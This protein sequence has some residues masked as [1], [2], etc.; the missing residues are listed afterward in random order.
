MKDIA[1]SL[2]YLKIKQMKIGIIGTGAI[3]GTIARKLVG[4]G[5]QVKVANTK[6][7][8]GVKDFARE[9]AAEPQDIRGV[10]KDVEII[11][12]SI[13][14]ASI[15]EL[16]KDVFCSVSDDVVI[17]DSNN[18]YPGRKHGVIQEIEDGM[19]ES[20]WVS[21]QIGRSVIKAFNMLLAHTL[22]NGGKP[23]NDKRRLG[24]LVAGDNVIK[25]EKVMRLVEDMGFDAIDNGLLKDSW[26]QQ[27][28]SPG[29]C[30]DYT[31][32]MLKDIRCKSTA[33]KESVFQNR[34]RFD[35]EFALLAN[36]DFSHEN[37]I[38]INRDFNK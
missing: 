14:F 33:T 3:G 32:E 10:I 12:L 5:H 15:A 23:Q 17:V 13:P 28:N 25:K 4:A 11:V 19:V 20:L 34:K 1:V 22:I 29:Y 38:R 31:A 36:D 6:G 2:Q 18:Y 37:V 9:I 8:E 30:C 24:M 16:P 35:A 26:S 21:E 27:P 7:V